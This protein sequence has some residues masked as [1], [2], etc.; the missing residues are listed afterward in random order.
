[1]V[2]NRK[3]VTPTR[4]TILVMFAGTSDIPV[5]EEAAVTAEVM[6]NRVER[7]TDVRVTGIQ[8]ILSNR[9]KIQAA[10]VLVTV[11]GMDG[12]LHSITAGSTDKPVIVVPTSIGYGASFG[13]LAALLIILNSCANGATVGEHR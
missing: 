6:G 10:S 13:G 9:E 8:S 4:K 12:A 5:A 2:M 3:A 11:A 7:L 1:M